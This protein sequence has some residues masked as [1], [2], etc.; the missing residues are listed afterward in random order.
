MIAAFLTTTL[1]MFV[2][3][4]VSER[5]GN[6]GIVDVAWGFGFAV[7]AL[8]DTALAYVHGWGNFSRT[9]MILIMVAFWSLRLGFFLAFRFKRMWPEE[10]GRYKKYRQDW[11]SRA[12]LGLFL[13]FEMQAVLL[14]SLTLPFALA[15]T[16]ANQ[17][18]SGF[19]IAGFIIWLVA[20]VCETIS[21]Q[22]LEGFKSR[23]RESGHA[24]QVNQVS[25]V[26]QVGFWN[27]SRHPNYFFEW[28]VWLAFFCFS[29][30]SPGGIYTIY[31][32]LLMLLF[33]TKVT[34]VKATEEQAVRSKGQAYIEYQR[35]T[36]AFVPWFKR[37]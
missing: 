18:I 5:I 30:G 19:E 13:A 20:F 26:C 23:R 21:D 4:L 22:Q 14:A 7:V 32:P 33:L 1:M 29:L 28:L 24:N 12:S 25:Q 37:S 27:Y 15:L 8:V 35:T 11:G 17:Q 31:C 2:I 9:A 10:D 6:A 16:N 36:S 3:W 34:G